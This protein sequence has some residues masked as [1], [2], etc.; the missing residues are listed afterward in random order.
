M[1]WLFGASR[2]SGDGQFLLTFS[3]PREF[4]WGAFTGLQSGF[5]TFGCLRS[6]YRK[7]ETPIRSQP[8]TNGQACG[9]R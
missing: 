7:R 2:C 1:R 9:K 6:H 4:I 5:C 8:M 3:M